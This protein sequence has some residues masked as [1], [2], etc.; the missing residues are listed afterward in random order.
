M[1]LGENKSCI[2]LGY[3][4]RCLLAE[5]RVFSVTC[6]SEGENRCTPRKNQFRFDFPHRNC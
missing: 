4:D 5:K 6:I 2:A 1:S 3:G